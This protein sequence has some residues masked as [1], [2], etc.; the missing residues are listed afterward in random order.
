MH[1]RQRSIKQ[2][3]GLI[4]DF[5]QILSSVATFATF[6][7]IIEERGLSKIFLLLP[8]LLFGYFVVRK[9][10]TFRQDTFTM[11]MLCGAATGINCGFLSSI[12]TDLP[13]KQNYISNP[14]QKDISDTSVYV[15]R[16]M[17]LRHFEL[18]HIPVVIGSLFYTC[19]I[20]FD[21]MPSRQN[22][23]LALTTAFCGAIMITLSTSIVSADQGTHVEYSELAKIF[24]C[25]L[26]LAFIMG[27]FPMVRHY[28][29]PWMICMLMFIVNVVWQQS[30]FDTLV[31]NWKQYHYPIPGA[32][33]GMAVTF[34]LNVHESGYNSGADT[35]D[36]ELA[37]YLQS[38]DKP[39]RY[40]SMLT[41]NTQD[42]REVLSSAYLW[43]T[44]TYIIE[45]LSLAFIQTAQRKREQNAHGTPHGSDVSISCLSIIAYLGVTSYYFRSTTLVRLGVVLVG[46]LYYLT[47]TL[48]KGVLSNG[49]FLDMIFGM[50]V[51]FCSH[52]KGYS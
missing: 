27:L 48:S 20:V 30:H 10:S 43:H 9:V 46:L 4:E 12:V 26:I 52:N 37:K 8:L 13:Q 17:V 45:R 44:V 42:V 49:Y 31:W 7:R 28:Q 2:A 25:M 23:Q 1:H 15:V 41:S 29:R 6:M 51:V 24:V 40:H 22:V 14:I 32:I 50:T 38:K 21:V 18:L 5:L 36:E 16:S 19:C 35:D 33:T 34:M 3:Y 47:M 39:L 11:A